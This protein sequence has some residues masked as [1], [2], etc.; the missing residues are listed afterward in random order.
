MPVARR[1]HY[2]ASEDVVFNASRRS[3][4]PQKLSARDHILS[5]IAL[6]GSGFMLRCVRCRKEGHVDN[7]GRQRAYVNYFYGEDDPWRVVSSG[8][9][10]CKS[11]SENVSYVAE[12][13]GLNQSDSE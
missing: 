3:S 4:I 6:N 13:L 2:N 8:A 7:E 9:V 12:E 11:C 5:I 10:Y 1:A